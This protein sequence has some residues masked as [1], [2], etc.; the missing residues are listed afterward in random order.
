MLTD[1]HL[2]RLTYLSNRF[3][4]KVHE[5]IWFLKNEYLDEAYSI[6]K[7]MVILSAIAPRFSKPI[8]MP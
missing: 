3:G 7:V 1:K 2:K 4:N 6:D 8:Q 5:M